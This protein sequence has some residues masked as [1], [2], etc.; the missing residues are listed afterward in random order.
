MRSMR[1]RTTSLLLAAGLLCLALPRVDAQPNNEWNNKPDVFQVNRLPAHATLVPYGDVASA[2]LGNRVGSPYYYSLDGTWKFHLATN[3]AGRDTSFY[4]DG[5]DVSGWSDI[6]V[7]GNWQTQGF[8]YPIYTNFT[9][10]WTGYENPAPPVAPTVY[11]P[12]GAYRRDFTVP[13][14]WDGREI[15]LEFQGVGS[16][17]YVWVNGQYVGYGEDTFTPKDYDVTPFLRSGTNNISVEVYRWSDGSWLEDQDMIRLS[18]IV[19]EMGLFSTPPVHISDFRYTTD[20]DGSYASATLTVKASVKYFSPSAPTGYSVEATVIASDGS[21]VTSLSLGTATF[22]SGKEIELSN[23]TTVGNPLKW[24]AEHPNLYT[25]VVALKDQGGN[26][27][28]TESSDLGFRSFQMI[29]GQMKINGVPILFKGVDRHEIDPDHGKTLSYNRMVQDIQIMKRF[30]IN[31]VRTSHYPND[32]RWYDLCDIYGIYVIDETNLES[33]GVSNI[34]PASKPEW[35]QNCLDRVRSMVE[36]DKNRPCVVIWSLG[37]EAGSGSNFQAMADWVHQRDPSRLVHYEGQNSVA[38]MTS[39]MYPTVETVEAY[40]ASGNSKPYIMCEYAHAMGNSEGDLYQYW[41]VIQKH[42]N[43]QGAF[44][45]DF[46]D[47][48]LTNA[49]G[50]FSYGGDWGDNPN[51]ADFCAN[52]LVSADRTLQPEIFEV[53]KVYQNIKATPVNLLNGQ[54]Q[55]TNYYRFTNVNAFNGTW[56][57]MADSTQVKG[58][59]FTAGDLDIPPMTSKAVTVTL[60]TIA[61]APG[62]HYWL[63]LSFTQAHAELWADAGYEIAS[64]Q[65][66]IPVTAVAPPMIDTT[67]TPALT[68]MEGPDSIV[69]GNSNLHLVFNKTTGTIVSYIYQGKAL[70]QQGPVPNFWRAPNSSDYGDGMPSRCGT[71]EIASRNRT[72]GGVVVKVFSAKQIQVAVSFEYPT[73]TKSSGSIL[74]D[75]YGDGNVVVTSTLVPGSAQ[76]PEIPEIGMLSMVPASFRRVTWYGRGPF[77]NYWDRKTGSNVGVHSTTIDSMFVSYIRP[78]ETG[79]RTDVQWMSLTDNTG[80]GLLAVGMPFMEFN[81]LRYT[82]WELESKKHPYELTMSSDIVLRLS[83]HQMGV[84]G[85]NSWGMRPHPEFTMYSDEAYTYR[86]RLLPILAS[87]SAMSLS[88][89]SFPTP[90][91]AIVPD[92]LSLLHAAADSIIAASGLAVG[93]VTRTLSTSVPFD[94]VITQSPSA[95]ALVPLGTPVKLSISLGVAQDVAQGKPASASTEETSKGNTAN[96]G[97]DGDTGTRWCASDGSL[98]QWWTVDLGTAY[99]VSGT[100]VMWEMAG[101]QYCYRIDVSPNNVAWTLAVDKTNDSTLAQTRTDLFTA[102]SVRY[103]RITVTR[104][105]PAAWA[106]FWD[107]KVFVLSPE[108]GVQGDNLL[109]ADTRLDQNYPNPFNPVTTV[110]YALRKEGKVSITIYN[111]LGQRVK[112]LIDADQQAGYKSIAWNGTNDDGARVGSGVYFC[113]MSADEYVS[114]KKLLLLK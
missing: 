10:P 113:R 12:V 96:K 78:Q 102:K 65:F 108:G 49:F 15:F 53:K 112:T 106:S 88:K 38:D 2:I 90:Q 5:T 30:N 73:S 33:H 42:P 66:E 44:I 104:L 79:N 41:D 47:Q 46:V 91:M 39:N 25:L 81:A 56:K 32:P 29:G 35:T 27:I 93:N 19:R 55:L 105:A 9:Y 36:R 97:N 83:Y 18:G 1:N 11:N 86:F 58:G 28:E 114:T 51:D 82:P 22:T 21:Q 48:G 8:D 23:S 103:V 87:Q 74:Y 67:L 24:S 76:L 63:N 109:P 77:E 13:A 92:V 59:S 99:T 60:G 57:L 16:A 31:A 69:V 7:P 54:F 70:L 71:W 100:E 101:I 80:A 37:N 94:R 61:P 84:G 14:G 89:H 85:D 95:G 4:H 40:G 3:P 62:V 72:V 68:A 20:F 50:G 107:F 43:L 6:Q 98:N 26:I 34:V 45:W 64:E 75:V 110:M 52:G 17:F 111:L